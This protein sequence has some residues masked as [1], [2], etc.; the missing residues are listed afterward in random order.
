MKKNSELSMKDIFI[1]VN[2]LFQDSM[3]NINKYI[4]ND[5]P[6]INKKQP[7][8]PPYGDEQNKKFFGDSYNRKPLIFPRRLSEVFITTQKLYLILKELFIETVNEYNK[9]PNILTNPAFDY[10]SDDDRL[11]LFYK[12]IAGLNILI[13]RIMDL[14]TI[15]YI[16]LMEDNTVTVVYTGSAHSR[17]LFNELIV[18]EDYKILEIEYINYI[19]SYNSDESNIC[20]RVFPSFDTNLDKLNS[21]YQ[22]IKNMYNIE[23]NDEYKK[24]FNKNMLLITNHRNFPVISNIELQLGYWEDTMALHP[25]VL[26]TADRPYY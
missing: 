4:I 26:F 22:N 12:N 21:N 2:T 5:E 18:F 9:N 23:T 11:E 3:K 7:M 8:P 13:A 19:H 10:L 15:E 16:N 6:F 17:F 25:S 1:K 20:Q 24:N 14:Y